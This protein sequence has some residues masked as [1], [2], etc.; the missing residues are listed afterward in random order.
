LLLDIGGVA[1][2]FGGEEALCAKIARELR[3]RGY[4]LRLGVAD[5]I[6]AA[7]AVGNFRFQISL[8]LAG[9]WVLGI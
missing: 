7:W 9:G 3:E 4:D 5:T 1:K 6:G 8:T 2:L